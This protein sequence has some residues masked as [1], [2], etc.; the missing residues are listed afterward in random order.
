MA[1]AGQSDVLA[2]FGYQRLVRDIEA[3]YGTLV[4]S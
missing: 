4:A 1:A 2:R 3:L